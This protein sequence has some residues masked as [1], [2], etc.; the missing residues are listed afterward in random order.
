MVTVY[1]G[2]TE[3]VSVLIPR[4]FLQI[5]LN[6]FFFFEILIPKVKSIAVGIFYRPPNVN[7]FFKYISK[8]FPANWQQ[9]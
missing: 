5:L 6:M 7:Y 9:N 3:T 4:I 8:R 2:M 1:L